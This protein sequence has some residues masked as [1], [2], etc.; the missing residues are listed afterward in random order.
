LHWL[1][2]RQRIEF[3]LGTITFRVIY[4]GVPGYLASGNKLKTHFFNLS[5]N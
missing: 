1:P 3:K 5:Y 2:I 4:T